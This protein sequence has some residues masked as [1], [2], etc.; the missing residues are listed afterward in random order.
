[1]IKNDKDFSVKLFDSKKFLFYKDF[2]S[3]LIISEQNEGVGVFSKRFTVSKGNNENSMMFF[4]K[5]VSDS[6]HMFF[7]VV[8]FVPYSK[9]KKILKGTNI[10]P[11]SLKN[12]IPITFNK[13][14]NMFDFGRFVLTA[15]EITKAP[16]EIYFS[17]NPDKNIT[18]VNIKDPAKNSVKIEKMFYLIADNG[19]FRLIGKK[20]YQIA[21]ITQFSKQHII[22]LKSLVLPY[23]FII[24]SIM[25]Y[26]KFHSPKK[27]GGIFSQD[28]YKKQF[29]EIDISGEL[30]PYKKNEKIDELDDVAKSCDSIVFKYFYYRAKQQETM[31]F[32][33]GFTNE[34]MEICEKIDDE[35]KENLDKIDEK[36]EDQYTMLKDK[37]SK[38]SSEDEKQIL[39][40]YRGELEKFDKIANRKGK[41][42]IYILCYYIIDSNWIDMHINNTI[43]TGGMPE[44]LRVRNILSQ[45]NPIFT[46]NTQ[47]KDSKSNFKIHLENELKRDDISSMQESQLKELQKAYD[48]GN[49]FRAKS[50][51]A[52]EFYK[53]YG[54][55]LKIVTKL[56]KLKLGD[57]SNLH[58]SKIANALKLTLGLNKK[59][60]ELT[61]DEFMIFD[62]RWY[63]TGFFYTRVQ[64]IRKF[65]YILDECSTA[66]NDWI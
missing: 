52:E 48:T 60:V 15:G 21:T 24:M 36:L 12:K 29:D 37:Y 61:S 56:D 22:K 39:K 51:K 45:S 40:R 25:G 14:Y 17:F 66:Y 41:M 7:N 10:S 6:E 31:Y 18:V 59:G 3:E 27:G 13:K 20:K 4:I 55:M 11:Q 19:I 64:G 32:K 57:L 46:K 44:M 16:L 53:S 62:P 47:T 34:V 5:K 35:C 9:N 26:L 23:E 63:L 42:P 58:D 38:N 50:I 30:E 49:F 65:L 8:K 43:K 2:D 28:L 1:M 33:K 54:E